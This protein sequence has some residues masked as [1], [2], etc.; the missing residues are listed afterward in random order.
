MVLMGA[1]FLAMML[2]IIYVGA[3]SVLFLFVVMMLDIKI[4][5]FYC[6]KYLDKENPCAHSLIADAACVTV[7]Q[8]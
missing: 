6:K 5:E 7:G 8:R 1:E 4:A 3:V 2:I